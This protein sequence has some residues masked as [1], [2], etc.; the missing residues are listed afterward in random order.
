[1]KKIGYQNPFQPGQ[2]MHIK[3]C[4]GLQSKWNLFTPASFWKR[5]FFVL[6]NERMGKG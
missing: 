5:F 6:S 4:F 1:M 2:G 3:K